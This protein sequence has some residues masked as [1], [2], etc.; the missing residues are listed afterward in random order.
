MPNSSSGSLVHASD[1]RMGLRAMLNT[2]TGIALVAALGISGLSFWGSQASGEAASKS[3]V[4]K[5]VTADV[6][7]PPMYLIEMRLV[8]SQAVEGNMA[9]AM[10]KSEIK[11]LQAEYESRAEFWRANPPFGLESH[12]LGTQHQGG[13]A[14]I[15]LANKTLDLLASGAT[16]DAVQ[17]SLKAAHSTYLLHRAGVDATVKES[18]AFAD[19]SIAHYDTTTQTMRWMQSMGLALA[20]A[21]VNA[22][23]CSD[24][25]VAAYDAPVSCASCEATTAV[26]NVDCYG[27]SSGSIEVTSVGGAAPFTVTWDGPGANDGTDAGVASPYLI[28]NLAAGAYSVTIE[29]ANGCEK[30]LTASITQPGSPLVITALPTHVS[31][32]GAN[33]GAINLMVAGGTFPYTF[34]WSTDGP[35]AP[36]ANDPEDL[37]GLAPGTYTVTVTDANGCQ[38]NSSVIISEPAVLTASGVVT[39]VTCFSASTG[40]I[41]LTA[42]GGTAPYTYDW[43][44]DGPDTP[45]DDAGDLTGLAAGTYAVTVTDAQG[46]QYNTSFYQNL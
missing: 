34:D 24:V 3:F 26:V 11:R 6:L 45:D 27:A 35:D 15:A 8:L 5:D 7:P 17:S 41:D 14:F 38:T 46:C 22:S 31:C 2:L 4:A 43:D 23:A 44:N 25:L 12:L 16:P 32:N 10:A 39:D 18:I 28:A 13:L 19:Q 37:T 33:D 29:D 9:F 1:N 30:I 40:A 21:F 20:A 36:P 42:A